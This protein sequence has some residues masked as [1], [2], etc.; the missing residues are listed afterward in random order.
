MFV[1]VN[2]HLQGWLAWVKLGNTPLL[3]TAVKV[4]RDK[5]CLILTDSWTDK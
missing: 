1:G 5:I 2:W 4:M 3:N